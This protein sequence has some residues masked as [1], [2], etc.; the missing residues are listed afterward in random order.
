V[1]QA[2]EG[3]WQI[4]GKAWVKGQPEPAD[5]QIRFT[6]TEA[7]ISG[8]ASIFGSPFAGTPI[9]FDELRVARVP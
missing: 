4:E 8:R 6:E 9:Q 2:K 3:E 1:R 5:W 7:P